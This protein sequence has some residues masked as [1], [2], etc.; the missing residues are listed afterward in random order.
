MLGFFWWPILCHCPPLVY[1]P[2]GCTAGT[3]LLSL[4]DRTLVIQLL[5]DA[6]PLVF[7]DALCGTSVKWFQFISVVSRQSKNSESNSYQCNIVG[8]AYFS[9]TFSGLGLS[10]V[11]IHRVVILWGNCHRYCGGHFQGLNLQ[12]IP[13]FVQN[14]VHFSLS[15]WA[16][17]CSFVIQETVKRAIGLDDIRS[18]DPRRGDA[19]FDVWWERCG[20]P[21]AELGRW[22]WGRMEE[23]VGSIRC[24]WFSV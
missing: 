13:N 20:G 10:W 4:R 16:H 6:I 19:G 24:G 7:C 12:R 8:M 9:Q 23:A 14:I 11:S 17:V 15:L 1:F 22:R 18:G 21:L 5:R 3:C 2:C